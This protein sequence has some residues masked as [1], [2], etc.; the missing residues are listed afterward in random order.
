ILLAMWR[1]GRTRRA[2]LLG[3]RHTRAAGH[4]IVSGRYEI[5]RD[6]V[7]AGHER[8]QF[9]GHAIEAEAHVELPFATRQRARV[10][11]DSSRARIEVA[12]EVTVAAEPTRARFR[13][14]R[15]GAVLRA[16]VQPQTGA[17]IERQLG[18]DADT[19][20]GFTSPLAQ[21]VTASRLR[22]RPGERRD[23]NLV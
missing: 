23:V 2:L 20:I 12:L 11:L 9:M 17:S 5:F 14:D 4:V 13:I 7:R 15:E 19:E 1:W 10:T 22:L 16:L 3:L 8:F 21:F 6:G 18:I